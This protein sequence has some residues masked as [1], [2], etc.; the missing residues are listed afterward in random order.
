MLVPALHGCFH[1]LL[2]VRRRFGADRRGVRKGTR[3]IDGYSPN[4]FSTWPIFC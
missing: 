4:S 1:F 3:N 2:R